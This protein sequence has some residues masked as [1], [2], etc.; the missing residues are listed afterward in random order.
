MSHAGPLTPPTN[1]HG[2]PRIATLSDIGAF[3][4]VSGKLLHWLLFAAGGG[5]Y[6]TFRMPKKA[7]GYR[8]IAR[9]HP[10]LRRVQRWILRNILDRLHA[11]ANSFG[12]EP[13]SRIR[14]HASQH[15]GARA[16]LSLDIESFFPSISIA[17]VTMVFRA[18]GYDGTVASLLAR[19]C[20]YRQALPQGAP[21]SPKI[22]SLV[23]SRMDRRLAGAS[24]RR[25]VVYT[26]YADDMSFS[27]STPISLAKLFPLI[28]QIVRNSGFRI[29]RAKT[30][31]MGARRSLKVTGLI[32]GP[33]AVG[34][35]RKR[36]RE[37]R[38]RIHR[39]HLAQSDGAE[40]AGIQG[41]LDFV[42]DVDPSRYKRLAK[43]IQG[44]RSGST[45]RR[46]EGLRL[47]E[48][49]NSA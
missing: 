45:E 31:L 8:T 48:P 9:P 32:V 20:T 39:L 46:L 25:E 47:R 44:L 14:E 2:L 18:A 30:R 4:G 38:A 34:I 33:E 29:N 13:G 12:F 17:Q 35:G 24:E 37:L 1:I 16:I 28:V 42:S 6:T 27:S 3:S 5:A 15:I 7:G 40:I 43:Y 11:S 26:R 19:L 23:C 41:W 10:V 49:L 36:L 21:T 22:A